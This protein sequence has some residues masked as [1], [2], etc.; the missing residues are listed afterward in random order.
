MKKGAPDVRTDVGIIGMGAMIIGV[1]ALMFFVYFPDHG[2]MLTKPGGCGSYDPQV[3]K[4]PADYRGADSMDY[5]A[6]KTKQ[7]QE[8]TA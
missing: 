3:I 5:S 1:T 2:S 4:P 6:A 8:G 7:T